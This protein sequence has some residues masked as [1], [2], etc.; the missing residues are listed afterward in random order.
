MTSSRP[1]KPD[2]AARKPVARGEYRERVAAAIASLRYQGLPLPSSTK[3][4][5]R[6]SLLVFAR[7]AGIPEFAVYKKG[8]RELI[9]AAAE[10]LGVA[11]RIRWKS[12]NA[13]TLRETLAYAVA[14]QIK[15]NKNKGFPPDHGV[16]DLNKV[17]FQAARCHQR[18]SS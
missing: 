13:P 3:N 9:E 16:P 15:S 4:P 7:E 1:P 5:R 8:A 14:E 10:E 6:L 11:L 2:T 12:T 18:M 17:F